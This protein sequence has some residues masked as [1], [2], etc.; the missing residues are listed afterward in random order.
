MEPT[1][2]V[3]F[4]SL[5]EV[6]IALFRTLFRGARMSTRDASRAA[7]RAE[8]AM[9]RCAATN[10]YGAYAKSLESSAPNVRT[11]GFLPLPMK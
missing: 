9:R 2:A 1:G 4:K 7:R 10:G 8:L 3:N 11:A 6:K 5:P